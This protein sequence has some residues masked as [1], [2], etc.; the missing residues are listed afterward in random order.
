MSRELL[1]CFNLLDLGSARLTSALGA[2]QRQHY[3]GDKQAMRS[4]I[5]AKMP[6]VHGKSL[7]L[8]PDICPVWTFWGARE[9]GG[10]ERTPFGLWLCLCE[11]ADVAA[12]HEPVDSGEI[13]HVERVGSH[14][15]D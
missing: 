12:K 13:L 2:E 3:L 9:R 1:A 14:D 11:R 7:L 8:E 5:V 15:I 6:L 4:V 10:L